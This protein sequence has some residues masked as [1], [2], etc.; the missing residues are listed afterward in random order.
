ILMTAVQLAQIATTAVLWPSAFS[1][2][3]IVWPAPSEVLTLLRR[4]LPFA[5][6]GLVAN[7]QTRIGPLLLGYLST[8]ADVGASAAAARFGPLGRRAPGAVFAGALPVLSR[9]FSKASRSGARTQAAFDRALTV[10]AISA[11]LPMVLV[12]APLVR[13]VYGASFGPAAPVLV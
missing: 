1:G 6:A 8:E 13:I 11:A 10:F 7:L 3:S 4:A 12:A 9:E 2:A 5:A